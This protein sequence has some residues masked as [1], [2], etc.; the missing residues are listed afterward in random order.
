MNQ[1]NRWDINPKE[2]HSSITRELKIVQN[3]VRNLIGNRHW[4]EEGRF[5]EAILKNVIKRF[6]PSNISIGTGFIINYK[7]NCE[8]FGTEI[9][10]Q[11]D[12]ILYDNT[13]PALFVEG[14]FVITTP[15]NVKGIIEVK[16][17]VNNSNIKEIMDNASFN[18]KIIGK[19][20]FNGI[21]AYSGSNSLNEGLIQGHIIAALKNSQG[22]V[23]HI[24]MGE[25]LFIKLWLEREMQ[26]KLNDVYSIYKIENL[27]F[28]YFIS[29]LIENIS[30]KELSKRWWFLYP[31]KEGKENFKIKDICINDY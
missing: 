24:C 27:S 15:D 21:F 25:N 26:D 31:I 7:H 14:D 12:I 28:S 29:N 8:N 5:K 3:R 20:K 30:E 1:R 9:S 16:T 10:K 2:F 22:F 13:Y 18:G 4:G 17:K 19:S 23:N 11:I 6:L